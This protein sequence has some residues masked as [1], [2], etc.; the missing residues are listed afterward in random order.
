MSGCVSRWRAAAAVTDDRFNA[1]AVETLLRQGVAAGAFP[2]G[3]A[4]WGEA[5]APPRMARAG[6]RGLSRDAGPV[7]PGLIYDLASLTKILSTTSLAMILAR[8]KKL[9][10]DR[11]LS[12][13]PLV[14]LAPLPPN[15]PSPWAEI[16]PI[17]LL[18]HQ[19]GLRPWRPFYRLGGG[20]RLERR[21]AVLE[22]IW[23][24]SPQAAPGRRT[25]YSDLNFILLGLLLEETEGRSLEEMFRMEVAGPLGLRSTGYRPTAGPLAPTEDGFR[26]GGPAAHPEAAILGPTPLGRPHDDNAA[27]LGGVAGHA[28][29]F[30]PAL[31]AWAIA[32]DWSLAWRQGRGRI[33]DRHTLADF[34]RPRPAGED[35][36]RP[37]GFNIRGGVESMARSGLPPNAVG[38][39]GYTGT[40]LWWDFEKNF[41]WLLFTNR[42]HPSARNAAWIPSQY[43]GGP[44]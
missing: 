40:S 19:S 16:T 18:T 22:T 12:E 42:V 24:E 37:L 2:G 29:L 5:D 44:V 10:L 39:L 28:G 33:F 7:T 17:H 27:F 25:I 6:S 3:L 32:A 4:L 14:R 11:P 43:V 20:S 23:R 15:P 8:R 1:A 30:A 36:G 21:Q 41:I 34:I 35:S 38:H 9:E 13:S 26:Y 31:E